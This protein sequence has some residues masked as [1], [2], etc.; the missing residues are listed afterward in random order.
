MDF[1]TIVAL[2]IAGLGF[3]YTIFR[4]SSS[5]T[6]ICSREFRRLKRRYNYTVV[7]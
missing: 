1:G 7:V 4:D 3:L 6:T 2:V 5:D